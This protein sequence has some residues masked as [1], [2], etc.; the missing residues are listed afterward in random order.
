MGMSSQY[1][2]V[3]TQQM[4]YSH[5]LSLRKQL[6]NKQMKL[7]SFL[8]SQVSLALKK[9][10]QFPNA[11]WSIQDNISESLVAASSLLAESLFFISNT[12]FQDS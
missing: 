11:T 2:T 8:L 6:G 4:A 9:P 3:P 10:R 12:L 1:S 7:L 5:L